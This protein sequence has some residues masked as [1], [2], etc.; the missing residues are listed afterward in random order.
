MSAAK[1]IG[2]FLGFITTGSPLGALA[3]YALGALF[4]S[5]FESLGN[6]DNIYSSYNNYNRGNDE[7]AHSQARS[8]YSGEGERNSFLFSFLALSAY[9]IKADGKIMH[10]EMESVRRFLRNNFGI[11]AEHQGNDI[12]LKIFEQQ[13]Q[14]G[15]AQF[16]EVIFSACTEISTHMP[17]EQRLQ[18]LAFLMQIAQADGYVHPAETESLKAVAQ[19]LGIA[20]TDIDSILNLS[21]NDLQSAYTVLG[22]TPSATNDE[23]KT[24]YRQMALKHHP[25]RVATLG[26]DVR[27]AAERKFQEINDAK[28]RIFKARGMS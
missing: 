28:E 23:V 10:S 17:Y 2:G 25:D 22:I 6:T 12:L 9:I 18:L 19:G 15:D 16:R 24:A 13:K 26:N 14:M 11:A 27:K 20:H 1:W 7:Y 3:G 8:S 5:G 21:K 4:S